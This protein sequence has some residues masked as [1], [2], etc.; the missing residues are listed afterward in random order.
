[1]LTFVDL[2]HA[3]RSTRGHAGERRGV[4]VGLDDA[5]RGALSRS[6]SHR[7]EEMAVDNHRSDSASEGRRWTLEEL[8]QDEILQRFAG[9]LC[10]SELGS[11]FRE[12]VVQTCWLR[13]LKRCRQA[14]DE[15]LSFNS[16]FLWTLVR[17]VRREEINKR[18]RASRF[19]ADSGDRQSSV[20]DAPDPA[21]T[22]HRKSWAHVIGG[23][24]RGCLRRLNI[25]RRRA[26]TMFLMGFRYK[27]IAH[28]LGYQSKSVENWVNRGRQQLRTCLEKRGITP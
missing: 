18:M 10:Q 14:G 19:H 5:T 23:T 26:L 24:I 12:D 21:P 16:S 15:V 22:P 2:E 8:E 28:R 25:R 9:R 27:E 6:S 13:L 11:S 7:G 1:M 17:N 20:V 3:R 4:A